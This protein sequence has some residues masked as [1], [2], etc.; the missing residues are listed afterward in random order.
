[1]A[2][3]GLVKRTRVRIRVRFRVRFSFRV[4][5]WALVKHA[6]HW[7]RLGLVAVSE[8]RKALADVAIFTR[9]SNAIFYFHKHLTMAR[10]RWSNT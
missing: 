6:R 8:L 2:R 7:L 5:A 3:G 4:G 1:M 9:K 10:W